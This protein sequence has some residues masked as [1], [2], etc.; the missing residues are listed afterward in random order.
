MSY[1]KVPTIT[2]EQA[3]VMICNK[4]YYNVKFKSLEEATAFVERNCPFLWTRLFKKIDDKWITSGSILP[5]SR[6]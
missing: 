2:E 6:P 5:Q 3:Q 1:I 4:R